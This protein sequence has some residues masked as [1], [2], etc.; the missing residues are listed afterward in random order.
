M[1][2]ASI[3]AVVVA[4]KCQ[5]LRQESQNESP[6][7]SKQGGSYEVSSFLHCNQH[8]PGISNASGMQFCIAAIE[9]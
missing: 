7:E 2:T 8:D 3:P 1:L 5:S 9:R 4:L 6:L